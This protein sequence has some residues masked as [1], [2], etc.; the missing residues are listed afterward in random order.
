MKNIQLTDGTTMTFDELISPDSNG[1]PYVIT[2]LQERKLNPEDVPEELLSLK[3]NSGTSVFNICIERFKEPV[4]DD[5]GKTLPRALS[6]A[7]KQSCK[8]PLYFRENRE[9]I[10]IAREDGWTVA[11]EIASQGLLPK[12]MMTEEI[13]SWTDN[14]GCAVAYHVAEQGL[15]DILMLDDSQRDCIAHM[16]VRLKKPTEKNIAPEI[17]KVTN[18]N[19]C[20][21]AYHVAERNPFPNWAKHDKNI[22]LLGNGQGD[23]VAHVLAQRGYLP[24]E[25]MTPDILLLK[26][27]NGTTVLFTLVAGRRL[28]LE[29]LLLPLN[30][31]TKVF[32]YLLSKEFQKQKPSE[33]DMIYLGKQC[34]KLATL[35]QKTAIEKLSV[36]MQNNDCEGIER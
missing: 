28:S 30:K 24:L 26:K 29:I 19:R 33:K 10:A 23:Y 13:L 14:I 34:A 7:S 35:I 4:I 2:L 22:L 15:M 12:N 32:E 11:H 1:T 31:N 16:T 20:S 17:L 8:L 5:Y 3:N 25:M 9:V 6:L 18:G 21:I 27:K 36:Q